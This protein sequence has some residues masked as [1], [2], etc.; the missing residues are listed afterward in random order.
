MTERSAVRWCVPRRPRD[1]LLRDQ[2][3]I[4][5]VIY[6]PQGFEFPTTFEGFSSLVV[7]YLSPVEQLSPFK[8]GQIQKLIAQIAE[9]AG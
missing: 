1:E 2:T 8:V 7:K 3:L 4:C 5:S 6:G 9:S